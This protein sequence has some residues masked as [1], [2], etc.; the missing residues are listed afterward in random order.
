[1]NDIGLGRNGILQ[2]CQ[3]QGLYMICSMV[4]RLSEHL[5]SAETN[6]IV[7]FSSTQTNFLMLFSIFE[8][9][10]F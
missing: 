8:L 9:F 5:S 2:Y 3:A 1:M 7:N 6:N 4:L 10:F